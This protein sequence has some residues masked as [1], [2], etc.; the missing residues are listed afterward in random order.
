MGRYAPEFTVYRERRRRCGAGGREGKD[1]IVNRGSTVCRTSSVTSV[2]VRGAPV[3][4]GRSRS[5][6][7]VGSPLCIHE[8]HEQCS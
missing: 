5:K 4:L 8:S 2:M 6:R 1:S 7:P 3:Q